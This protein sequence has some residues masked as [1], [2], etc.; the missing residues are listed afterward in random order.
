[1][2]IRIL[3]LFARPAL[4]DY[5]FFNKFIVGFLDRC[6]KPTVLNLLLDSSYDRVQFYDEDDVASEYLHQEVASR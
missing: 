3:G 1:V 2:S 4:N 5:H 6:D